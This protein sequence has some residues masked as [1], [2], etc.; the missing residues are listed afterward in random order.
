[1]L[2]ETSSIFYTQIIKSEVGAD[3]LDY[4]IRDAYCTGAAFGSG[5]D[6][7]IIS[8]LRRNEKLAIEADAIPLVDHLFS[9]MFQ[10][11]RRVYDHKVAR[12]ALVIL[13]QSLSTLFSKGHPLKS[14]LVR[15][16]SP[17]LILEDDMTFLTKI[18]RLDPNLIQRFS[19][20]DFPH[21]VYTTDARQLKP[22]VANTLNLLRDKRLAAE[23]DLSKG[24][25][26]KIMLDFVSSAWRIAPA[27]P[28][29]TY[30]EGIAPESLADSKQL[31]RWYSTNA[32]EPFPEWRMNVFC[33]DPDL[34]K[35]ETTTK[36]CRKQFQYLHVGSVRPTIEPISL[37]EQAYKVADGELKPQAVL[38]FRRAILTLQPHIRLT[39]EKLVELGSPATASE[40]SHLTGRSRVVESLYLN[41]LTKDNLKSGTP[42]LLEKEPK[43]AKEQRFKLVDQ[44]LAAII[45]E[46]LDLKS[47]AHPSRKRRPE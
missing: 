14:F 38:S 27:I 11:K 31:E 47:D 17:N 35:R 3:R 29:E 1:M 41:Q 44:R 22:E 30:Q 39:L 46:F 28:I 2:K 42:K 26:A 4:L 40:V 24:A 9:I 7:R 18:G 12:A 32:H 37:L 23:R 8:H 15:S 5:L 10:M 16:S 45:Q 33:D 43:H 20:R 34:T 25:N 21:C 13:D 6:L 19:N 36:Y